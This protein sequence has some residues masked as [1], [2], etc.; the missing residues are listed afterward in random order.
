MHAFVP[1]HELRDVEIRCHARQLIGI[2]TGQVFLVFGGTVTLM[3][4]WTSGPSIERDA[5]WSVEELDGEDSVEV[6]E[7][8]KVQA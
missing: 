2:I 1:V 3:K 8:E 4:P 5:R 6:L 7:R